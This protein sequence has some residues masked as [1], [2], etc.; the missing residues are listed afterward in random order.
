MKARVR[1]RVLIA[2]ASIVAAGTVVALVANFTLAP[3]APVDVIEA[4]VTTGAG[5]EWSLQFLGDTMLGDGAQPLL[6][7]HGYDWPLT[8]MLPLVDGD[9]VIAN[10][11][12]PISEQVVPANPGKKY[13]Y[14]SDL[15]AAAALRKV[16]VDAVNLGNNHSMDMGLAGLQDTIRFTGAN[17]ILSFGAGKDI[18]EAERP[19][20]LRSSL[21]S[22]GIVSLGEHF[23]KSTKAAVEN[24]GTVVLSPETIQH[25]IDIAHA[26]GADWVVAHVHW[27]DNYSDTTSQQRYW[28]QLLVDAGYDLI[29]GTGPHV[30]API[31]FIGNVPVA[32]S[33]GNFA[34]GTPGRF[35]SFGQEGVGLLL[36]IEIQPASS[37]EL[38]VQCIV[39]D[40]LLN[41]YVPRPC[42][43]AQFASLINTVNP[44]LV[45]EGNVARMSCDCFKPGS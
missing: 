7:E 5:G 10:A 40:N 9:F 38:A 17:S 32:Y 36:S 19:L 22:V 27:G 33:I 45:L 44:A 12:G 21:G 18:A 1:D 20:I 34:F 37:A 42:G 31:E 35:K 25:G 43:D 11:E 16:G 8:G 30:V 3:S 24:P 15:R 26:A 29:V 13:S 2:A 4:S 39:T 6:D 23:G 28:A 14:N 41:D